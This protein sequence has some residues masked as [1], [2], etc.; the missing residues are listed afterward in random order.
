MKKILIGLSILLF[1]VVSLPMATFLSII[2]NAANT[3]NPLE[4]YGEKIIDM[5]FSMNVDRTGSV[6]MVTEDHVLYRW[7]GVT[8]GVPVKDSTGTPLTDVAQAGGTYFRSRL[9]YDLL[10]LRNDGTLYVSGD[11][12]NG[13]FGNGTNVNSSAADEPVIVDPG[14]KNIV[15]VEALADSNFLFTASGDVYASGDNSKGQLGNGTTVSS[16]IWTKVHVSGVKKLE[17]YSAAG[18]C[19]LT[20]SGNVYCWGALLPDGSATDVTEPVH[21]HDPSG[22]LTENVIDINSD[23]GGLLSHY[24]M[25]FLTEKDGKMYAGATGMYGGANKIVID[26]VDYTAT[27]SHGYTPILGVKTNGDYYIAG[28]NIP[29]TLP[30]VDLKNE[31]VY[32]ACTDPITF[33][34]KSGAVY[35]GGV[36]LLVGADLNVKGVKKDGT[37]YKDKEKFNDDISI[38]AK[39]YS[40]SA[41]NISCS[42][43]DKISGFNGTCSDYSNGKIDITLGNDRIYRTYTFSNGTDEKKFT[44]DLFK[45]VPELT[46]YSNVSMNKIKTT[47]TISLTVPTD[48]TNWNSYT[49]TVT[50]ALN[51][52]KDFTGGTLAEG[53]YTMH[54]TDA[55]GNTQ[56]YQFEV[57]DKPTP[58]ANFNPA[59]TS[60][61][62]GDNATKVNNTIGTFTLQYPAGKPTSNIA[63]IQLGTGGDE[64]HFSVDT[65]GALKVKGNDLDAGT[66]SVSVSGTDGNGMAFSKTAT[67]TV[68]KKDQNNYQITNNANYPF[69]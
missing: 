15:Q 5:Q 65:T 35:Y 53:T 24:G 44:V 49:A 25:A 12:S 63:T 47:D 7:D 26:H 56:D 13:R 54:V 38:I 29:Y 18:M 8:G 37:T 42:V 32:I 69:Q 66:Y 39:I 62:Y 28:S 14:I 45:K 31:I 55:Y 57:S 52:T 58:T 34:T 6:F 68:N 50:D 33:L 23:N 2:M 46:G 9:S 36:K 21:I 30:G 40:N 1:L 43:D 16:N 3:T 64:S 4:P 17:R 19:A 41:S 22:N 10:V 51:Q 60:L 61:T 67:I 59:N 27:V 20:D 48:Q 11:N